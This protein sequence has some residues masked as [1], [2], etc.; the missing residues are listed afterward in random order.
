M[1]SP[2][3]Q[4]S[5]HR[6]IEQPVGQH[7]SHK[8]FALTVTALTPRIASTSRGKCIQNTELFNSVEIWSKYSQRRNVDNDVMFLDDVVLA[9]LLVVQLLQRAQKHFGDC[10]KYYVVLVVSVLM[11]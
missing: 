2:P 5:F 7:I 8:F 4:Q 3:N 10:M 11:G 9:L 6:L 1:V